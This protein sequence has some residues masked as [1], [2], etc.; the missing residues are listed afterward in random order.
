M[1]YISKN[2]KKYYLKVHLIMVIKYRKPLLYN[3]E[4]DNSVKLIL[5]ELSNKYD[6][7]IESMESDVNHI[8]LLVEYPP[9]ISVTSIVRVLKQQNT[10]R[11]WL[12]NELLLKKYFW[13]EK[14]FWSDGYFV[15]SIGENEDVIHRYIINQ[16]K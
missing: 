6:F 5:T 14:T 11:L 2:R 15:S 8:H 7:N 13:K 10:Y 9:N 1:K 4:I 16:G 12:K 3:N